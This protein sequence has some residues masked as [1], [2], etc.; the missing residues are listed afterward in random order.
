MSIYSKESSRIIY[1]DIKSLIKSMEFIEKQYLQKTIL[2]LNKVQQNNL[3]KNLLSQ[4]NIELNKSIFRT[5]L[6]I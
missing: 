5:H 4:Y 2:Y 1:I 3:I 6:Y